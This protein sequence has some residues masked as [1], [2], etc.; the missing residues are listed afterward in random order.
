MNTPIPAPRPF[1]D[2]RTRSD[3]DRIFVR[4][5]V[6]DARIGAFQAERGIT[7]RLRFSITADLATHPHDT[8]H[9]PSGGLEDDVDRIVSYD[10]LL[11]AI[12]GVL[13]GR[14]INLLETVAESI[15][16]RVLSHG[17]IAQVRVVIEKLDRVSGVLGI[18][19]L[20]IL[21][22]ADPAPDARDAVLGLGRIAVVDDAL[23]Q[24]PDLA[25]RLMD[26]AREDPMVICVAAHGTA[27]A[28][29]P[30]PVRRRIDLLTFE[31]AAWRLAAFGAGFVVVDTRTE[32]DWGL[33]NGQVSVWAPSKM[34]LDA[35]DDTSG[36][37]VDMAH[38]A[39][40]LA[41]R[42]GIEQLITLGDVA[43][44]S[45]RGLTVRRD[46]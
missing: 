37:P 22:R 36:M 4:D 28:G 44:H 2:P 10:L 25:K 6:V 26:L 8:G 3:P 39:P 29:L 9:A 32:L 42:L 38:L 24:A 46:G 12:H 43:L 33:R 34:V 15:A 31:Q 21:A 14:H 16:V 17:A 20:R 11:D 40:W 7:Q 35:R 27:G 45:A 23:L 1:H 19:I 41:R 5:H 18:D 13:A 30:D